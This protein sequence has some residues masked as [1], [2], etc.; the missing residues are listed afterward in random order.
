MCFSFAFFAYKILRACRRAVART[1]AA[2]ALE[3]S[4]ARSKPDSPRA[5]ERNVASNGS[6]PIRK[7]RP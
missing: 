1:S 5:T 7:L 3:V 2:F 6:S 4:M